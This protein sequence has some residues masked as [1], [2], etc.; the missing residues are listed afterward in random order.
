MSPLGWVSPLATFVALHPFAAFTGNA[1]LVTSGQ[2]IGIPVCVG[3]GKIE[4]TEL[5]LM[6]VGLALMVE[7]GTRMLL[8][9]GGASSTRLAATSLSKSA[10]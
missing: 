4:V 9:S 7:L 5:V 8:D 1:S 3:S 10:F 6:V 2:E